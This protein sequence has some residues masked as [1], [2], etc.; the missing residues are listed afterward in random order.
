[1]NEL[2]T[3]PAVF[4]VGDCYQIMVMAK[5]EILF[6]VRV[7]GTDYFDHSN[8]IIRSSKVIHR[9]CVPMS[10]LDRAGEYTIFY[11]KIIERLPY[12]TTTEPP[13]EK[14]IKFYPVPTNRPINFYHLA[15]THG[16]FTKP[17]QSAKFFKDELDVLV[18]NGDIPD[19]SG[20]IENFDLIYRLCQ[21]ITK[22]EKPCIFSRG[23]HD[24]RGFYAEDIALYTPTDKGDSYFTFRLG[25][26]W[27]IVLDCGE[28]KDDSC[29]AYGNTVC[30]HQFRLEQTRFIENVIKNANTEYLADGVQNRI[31]IVHH[32]FSYIPKPP[33]DIEK[34]IFKNWLAL[35]E[36]IKPQVMISGHLHLTEFSEKG[37]HLDMLGQV[38]PVVV[39]ARFEGPNG[40]RGELTDFIGSAITIDKESITV[41]FTNS[42][43]KVLKTHTIKL[44]D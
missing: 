9:V 34:D 27:G 23:N 35:L 42:E 18:L 30:C 7:N 11:R 32:P 6:G 14:T 29:D 12:Y 13:V 20:S 21:D 22:G 44:N 37:G 17:A 15:D 4:A 25:N 28:D 31:V 38:C 10:Q 43:H 2:K 1:M 41:R 24:T 39:G 33:F 8:G 40:K 26:I 3:L 5:S 19:H 16:H 36:K